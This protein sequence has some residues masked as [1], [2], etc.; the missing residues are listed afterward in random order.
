MTERMIA[1]RNE[2]YG[3]FRE[4]G[5]DV[6]DIVYGIGKFFG[7][8]FVMPTWFR[9][10]GPQGGGGT[11]G[12]DDVEG[13][14]QIMLGLFGNLTSMSTIAI[15]TNKGDSSNY[16]AW[17]VPSSVWLTTNIAS[18]G[19]EWY[20]SARIRKREIRYSSLFSDREI[21]SLSVD[22]LA[23]KYFEMDGKRNNH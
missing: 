20:R 1:R 10:H 8:N 18:A 9:N 3:V 16:W 19:Y 6:S 14:A 17:A 12:G 2:N 23:Q 11:C 4:M 15:L 21:D 13:S 22:E 7:G 5:R